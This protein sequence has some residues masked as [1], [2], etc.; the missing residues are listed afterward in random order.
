MAQNGLNKVWEFLT[1]NLLSLN[2]KKTKYICFSARN[3]DTVNFNLKVHN[4]NCVTM[5][6]CRCDCP[7]LEKTTQLKYLGIVIDCTLTFKHHITYLTSR[8][9]KLIVVFKRLRHA[10]DKKLIRTIYLTLCQSLCT[11]GIS[12]WGGSPKTILKPLEVAQRAV[13]K[14][15]SFR[16]ILYPTKQLY[17]SCEVLTIR[18]LFILTIVL[19]QHNQIE[20]NSQS[21]IKRKTYSICKHTR[22]FR[23]SFAQRF[24]CFLGPYMYNRVNKKLSIYSKNKIKCKKE[25]TN[26]LLTL[27]Y[28]QN[29]NLLSI[30]K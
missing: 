18:Q 5:R 29:E 14:V 28:D 23:T 9:R 25:I 24:F 6:N 21:L 17:E 12:I 2:V 7:L 15:S 19:K 10:V 11:Y 20:Y 26:W 8:V 22:K 27:S 13:L 4:H 16:P 1:F 30:P 3:I